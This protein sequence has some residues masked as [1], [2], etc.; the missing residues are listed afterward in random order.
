MSRLT[1]NYA[2]LVGLRPANKE[3]AL[4]THGGPKQGG[5]IQK[6]NGGQ[7]QDSPFPLIPITTA[8]ARD[9]RFKDLTGVQYG[10][11]TVLG[12]TAN[13]SWSCR[14]QCGQYCLRKTGTVNERKR[15]RCDDC[16]H[17]AHLRER[18]ARPQPR[19]QP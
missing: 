17:T 8:M 19:R 11:L 10:R 15:D 3:A 2:S 7:G 9:P 1:T 13:G 5:G 12:R 14:C 6:Q 4:S 16:G 18:T